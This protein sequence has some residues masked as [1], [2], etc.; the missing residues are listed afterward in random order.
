MSLQVTALTDKAA[1]RKDTAS[2]AGSKPDNTLTPSN[3]SDQVLSLHRTVGNQ[4]AGRLLSSGLIQAKLTISQPDDVY[5]QEAD[6]VADEV[7]QMAEP[8]IGTKSPYSCAKDRACE[9]GGSAQL[10]PLISTPLMQRKEDEESPEETTVQAKK[11]SGRTPHLSADLLRLVR[12]PGG[13][14]ERL[15]PATRSFFEP[16]FGY[17]FSRVRVHTDPRAAEVAESLNAR[18]FTRGNDVVFGPGSY[19]PDT[20]CGKRL[21]AHELIHLIQQERS[22][23]HGDSV[24]RKANG[25]AAPSGLACIVARGEGHAS[26]VDLLFGLSST[27]LTTESEEVIARF[28]GEWI[29][30]GS[31]TD[32]SVDGYASTDG[33]EELNWRL[34]CDRAEEARDRLIKNGIPVGKIKTIAHG[35]T[36]EFSLT[37]L[38]K[39]RRVVISTLQASAKAV[40]DTKQEGAPAR[41]AQDAKRKFVST[42][43]HRDFQGVVGGFV[44]AR[45]CFVWGHP[46][47]VAADPANI[48]KPDPSTITYDNSVSGEMDPDPTKE[49]KC[50][51]T[52]DVDPNIVRQNYVRLCKP[53]NYN[54]VSFNCCTCAYLALQA[55]GA[56]PSAAN[57]PAENQGMALPFDGGWKR[58]VLET[59]WLNDIDEIEDVMDSLSDDDTRALSPAMKAHWVKRLISGSYCTEAEGDKVIRLF[60]STPVS[61]RPSLYSTVEGHAWTGDWKSGVTVIDDDMVDA[62]SNEQ[63]KTLKDIINGVK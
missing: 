10:R 30:G 31:Q 54:L 63:L 27:S 62:L 24:H 38:E 3:S 11:D 15:S 56:S 43:C 22:E 17:D 23:S 1:I 14:G 49:T 6:R 19:S 53:S 41:P 50:T 48:K 47:V 4:A 26:G 8:S 29:A 7:M 35:E 40:A 18:A 46:D 25:S 28:A 55:A 5:E 34:S 51:A 12:S 33:P 36:S 20:D 42:L 21:I 52:Y 58:T 32:V 61:G 39:N 59:V 16:R 44:P 13:G 2:L 57:F 9:N 60:K 37:S 45:H